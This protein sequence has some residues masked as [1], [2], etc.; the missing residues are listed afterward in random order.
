MM[1]LGMVVWGPLSDRVAIDY[2]LVGTGIALAFFGLVFV[3]DKT[4]LAAGK[5]AGLA[6]EQERAA[7][8]E[9]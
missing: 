7:L 6:E 3:F 9:G 8:V 1:P 2:L 5:A 4:M